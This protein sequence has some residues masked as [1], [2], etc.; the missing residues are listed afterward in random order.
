M[1]IPK[2]PKVISDKLHKNIVYEI[3]SFLTPARYKFPDWVEKNIEK[4]DFTVMARDSKNIDLLSKYKH[5]LDERAWFYICKLKCKESVALL[6]ENIDLLNAKCWSEI[7]SNPV[8]TGLI[9]TIVDRLHSYEGDMEVAENDLPDAYEKCWEEMSRNTNPDILKIFWDYPSRDS[10]IDWEVLCKN[11]KIPEIL[12]LVERNI[13]NISNRCWDIISGYD[14]ALPLLEKYDQKACWFNWKIISANPSPAAI[15]LMSRHLTLVVINKIA[16]NPSPAAVSIVY[17]I[18]ECYP[19][20]LNGWNGWSSICM[21]AL[22]PESFELIEKNINKLDDACWYHLSK[23]PNAIP[24]LERHVDKINW[25]VISENPGIF[26]RDE[27]RTRGDINKK[28]K[29]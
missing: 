10:L 21:H 26:I 8:A 25:G 9:R 28:M 6:S 22:H 23:N 3:Y 13:N 24:F 14:F 29:M 17:R 5:M 12:P 19:D 1:E 11:H 2:I 16:I 18:V 7:C 15:A 27:K 20:N 4:L